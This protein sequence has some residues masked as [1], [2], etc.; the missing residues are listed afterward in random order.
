MERHW[1][2]GLAEQARLTEEYERFCRSQPAS[3]SVAEQEQIR[4]LAQDIPQLWHADTTTAV[5]RQRLVRFLIEQIEVGVQGETDQVEVAIRWAGG[6]V[7]HH[8]LARA[9]QCYEQLADYPRL[10]ARIAELRGGEVDGRGGGMLEPGGL[11]PSQSAKRFS[12]AM[13]EGFLAK[14]GRSGPRP[15]ALSAA[16]L[17][18]KGEWLLTDLARHL[19]MPSA[20]LHRW[21]RV[22]WVHARKLPVPGGHWALW[23][24]AAEL[25]A[26]P[27]YAVITVR[28]VINPFPPN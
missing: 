16:G 10:P 25:S 5:E 6:F 15:V 14:N 23:A 4:S 17:L 9:V 2:E 18:Q 7:S 22:G 21:R 19:G 12:S 13:V 11:P 24:D 27:G 28:G 1:E 20:T 26:W 3:L 8:S